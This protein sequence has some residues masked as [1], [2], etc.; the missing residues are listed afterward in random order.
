MIPVMFDV[1]ISEIRLPDTQGMREIVLVPLRSE[2][3]VTSFYFATNN[4]D[5]LSAIR[6]GQQLQVM[7]SEPME[8]MEDPIVSEK[9]LSPSDE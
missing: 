7:I 9:P 1:E 2:Y 3:R 4:P 5:I 6:V 8:L